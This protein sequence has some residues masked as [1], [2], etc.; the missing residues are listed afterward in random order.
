MMLLWVDYH[1]FFCCLFFFL[2]LF[3]LGDGSFDWSKHG[4]QECFLFAIYLFII[5][6]FFVQ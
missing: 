4:W 5:D 1:Q 3:L 2:Y 6:D